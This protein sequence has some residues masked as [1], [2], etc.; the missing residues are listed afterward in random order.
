MERKIEIQ[1]NILRSIIILATALIVLTFL[2]SCD[3]KPI[4]KDTVK[5]GCNDMVVI[6]AEKDIESKDDYKYIYV[7]T[8][9][10]D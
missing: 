10:N 5:F 4:V 6:S 3:E 9:S 8:S 7:L 2:N 1:R